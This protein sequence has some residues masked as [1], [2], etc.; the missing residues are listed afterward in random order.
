MNDLLVFYF[1]SIK[2]FGVGDKSIALGNHAQF[3]MNRKV[4]KESTHL[5]KYTARG[6]L[7]AYCKLRWMHALHMENDQRKK[8]VL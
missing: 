8:N 1:S 4:P 3:Q 2:W 6:M 7:F 5:K